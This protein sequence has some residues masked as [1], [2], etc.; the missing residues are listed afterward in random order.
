LQRSRLLSVFGQYQ[1]ATLLV[2][3]NMDEAYRLCENL[4]V[5]EQGRAIAAGAKREIFEKP[6]TVSVARLTGCKN[7]S[8]AVILQQQQIEA[9][10]WGC[11]LTCEQVPSARLDQVGIRAYQLRFNEEVGGENVFPCWL[12]ATSET[13]HRMTLYLKLN[14]PPEYDGDYHLQA[15]VFKERWSVLQAHPFPWQVQLEPR[16]LILMV[17]QEEIVKAPLEFTSNRDRLLEF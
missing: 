3:H 2:T 12:A 11:T 17:E 10:D 4:L 5:L 9:I 6:Q 8:R 14:Q 15:E 7:Y 16:R 13:P 1:G